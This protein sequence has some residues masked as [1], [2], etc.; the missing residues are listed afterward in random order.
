MQKPSLPSSYARSPAICDIWQPLDNVLALRYADNRHTRNFPD[1]PLQ[2]PIVRRHKVNPVLHNPLHD[3][4]IRIGTLMIALQSLPA[5]VPC[6]AQRNPILWPQLLQLS[7]HTGGNDGRR[8]CIQQVHERLV[9]LEFRV[10]RVREEVGI[11][12][13]RVRR[14]QGGVG[15]EEERG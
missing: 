8:L 6:N 4:V 5:L 3:T 14:P 11:D 9:E 15:L 2:I 13:H 1:P 10:H 12:E 7:H